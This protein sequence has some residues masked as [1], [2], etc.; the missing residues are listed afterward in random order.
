MDPFCLV[1]VYVLPETISLSRILLVAK[2]N[3]SLVFKVE[4][5]KWL[6]LLSWP[7]LFLSFDFL[8]RDESC[9]FAGLWF[10]LGTCP[11]SRHDYLPI[12]PNSTY[13]NNLQYT[14]ERC[15]GS[16]PVQYSSVC[17]MMGLVQQ[18]LQTHK[19]QQVVITAILILR[20]TQYIIWGHVNKWWTNY[21]GLEAIWC[22]QIENI[23][24][25]VDWRN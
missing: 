21:L 24:G 9:V 8:S 23:T 25:P 15:S 20:L 1:K 22:S 12:L 18:S 2:S 7:Y 6:Q 16:T 14:D 13:F 19:V 11:P 5:L 10:S 17:I 3:V 4:K